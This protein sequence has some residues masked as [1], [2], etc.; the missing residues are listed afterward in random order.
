MNADDKGI[1]ARHQEELR[2][3][4]KKQ[5]QERQELEERR[6]KAIIRIHHGK[7]I[8]VKHSTYREEY[9]TK[10]DTR[11]RS[12]DQYDIYLGYVLLKTIKGRLYQAWDF[13]NE[14]FAPTRVLMALQH[15]EL[16]KKELETVKLAVEEAEKAT[17][18]YMVP[19]IEK[20]EK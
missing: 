14:N 20:E 8:V 1:N 19:V 15:L 11:S 9:E 12:C 2:Q 6:I 17:R 18:G 7:A 5:E 13:V 16:K 3:L 10:E 4:E